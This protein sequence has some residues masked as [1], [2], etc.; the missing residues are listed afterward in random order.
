MSLETILKNLDPSLFQSVI[1][2]I[3][4]IFIPF[5]IVFLMD[6]LDP[7]KQRNEFEKMV[8]VEQVLSV[9]MV[10][11]LSV[12]GLGFL[13]FFSGKNVSDITKLIVV[14]ISAVLIFYLWIPFKRVLKFSEGYKTEFEIKFLKG[15]QLFKILPFSNRQKIEK[16]HRSWKSLWAEKSKDYSIHSEKEFTKLFIRHIDNL[17]DHEQ[18]NEII[19]LIDAYIKNLDKRSIF[20]VK[21]DIFPKLFEWDRNFLILQKKLQ[22]KNNIKERIE[23]SIS[24]KYFPTLKKYT[25][26]ILEKFVIKSNSFYS[27]KYFRFKLFPELVKFLLYN[28]FLSHQLFEGFKNFIDKIEEKLEKCK[29]KIKKNK[30]KKDMESWFSNFCPVLFENIYK[31]PNKETIWSLNFPKEWKITLENSNA[32]VPRIILKC[33][34]KWTQNRNIFKTEY[35]KDNDEALNEVIKGIF[36]N[37]HTET[38]LSFLMLLFSYEIKD[39]I[40]KIP[41]FSIIKVDLVSSSGEKSWEEISHLIELKAE[42]K[43]RETVDLIFTYFK[44]FRPFRVYKSDLTEE[45]LK[46]WGEHSENQKNK[47]LNKQRK[48]KLEN[49]L[50]ELNS[51]DIIDFCKNSEYRKVQ[52]KYF[53]EL[54]KL[55]LESIHKH[56]P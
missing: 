38:F 33:F 43:K 24:K 13:A 2:G 31:S 22:K 41:R 9:R 5:S 30:L 19:S 53:I 16:I 49:I 46:N 27:G 29:N 1:L 21:Y 44:N 47:I 18:W 7:K 37:Y 14:F 23:K 12:L 4:A 56:F 28:Q 26:R 3:L 15:L 17:I 32:K 40:Q 25:L 42:E 20:S 39:A 51:K 8:L 10:F 11:W 35:L 50:N 45:Q 55:F 52:R 6:I 48:T 54:I 36:P 34:L